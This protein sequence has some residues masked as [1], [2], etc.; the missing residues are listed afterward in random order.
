LLLKPGD[1]AVTADGIHIMAYL[2]NRIWIEADPNMHKVIEV[3]V[4]TSN[5]WFN[6]PVVF[7]R[8]KWLKAPEFSNQTIQRM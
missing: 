7:V 4:P 5:Q 1:L 6:T 3:A 2:G 8:W